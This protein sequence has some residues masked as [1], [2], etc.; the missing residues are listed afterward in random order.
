MPD[1]ARLTDLAHAVRARRRELDLT[2]AELADL[3]GCSERFVYMLEQGK[4]TVQLT[5]LLEVLRALGLGLVVGPGHGEIA[6]LS[7]EQAL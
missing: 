3:A 6:Q 4:G 5:K 2:Q 7:E 1:P